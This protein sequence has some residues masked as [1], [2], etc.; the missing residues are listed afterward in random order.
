M[1]GWT[2]LNGHEFEST[3]GVGNGQGSLVC[4]STWGYKEWD[5]TETLNWTDRHRELMGSSQR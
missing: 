5:T 3:L 1:V 4:Y 2:Q